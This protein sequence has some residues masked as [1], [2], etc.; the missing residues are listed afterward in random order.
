[1]NGL[2]ND[3]VGS[4]VTATYSRFWAAAI[5]LFL[6]PFSTSIEE[7]GVSSNY[8]F[9]ILLAFLR[10]FQ[11][12][13]ILIKIFV[14]YAIF[15]YVYAVLFSS[16]FPAGEFYWRQI[17]SAFI[18][19]LPPLIMAV[20]LPFNMEL[21]T[22]VLVVCATVYAVAVIFVIQFIL[23]PDTAFLNLKYMIS[24]YIPDWPQR[25]FLVVIIGFFMALKL[26]RNHQGWSIAAGL[27]GFCILLTNLRAAYCVFGGGII[28]L[29]FLYIKQRSFR[30]I[31]T[32]A[33]ALAL[34]FILLITLTNRPIDSMLFIAQR[35]TTVKQHLIA[36]SPAETSGSTRLHVWEKLGD[37]ML[38]NKKVLGS[39]FAGPYLFFPEIGTAH[40]QYMDVLFRTGPIGLGIYLAL[41]LTLLARSFKY[42][43][44]LGVALLAWFLFG[45]LHETTKYSYGAFIFFTLLSLS[46]RGWDR[47]LVNKP[48]SVAKK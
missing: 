3:N 25:Y 2:M 44:E 19:T 29:T 31:K 45:L 37:F 41:W 39:G 8:S 34:A 47:S 6:V 22:R 30:S 1:M 4:D 28:M 36:E 43:P 12:W 23:P 18:F 17:I 10:P 21:L 26:A 27:C 13:P 33:A 11:E 42:S 20:L 38:E 32:A 46:Q 16:Q 48:E 9:L 7:F 35:I 40:N 24:A 5:I 15:C 14:P